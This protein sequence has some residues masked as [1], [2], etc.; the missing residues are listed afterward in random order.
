M[1]L[2]FLYLFGAL[3]LSFMCSILEAVLLSTP[4]SFISMKESQ[5]VKAA[6]RLK[7]YKSDID[8]PV[9]AILSLNTIAHTIGAAGVGSESVKIFGQEY[10][11]I[12]SAILTL[13]ILVFSEIIPKTVGASYWRSLAIPVTGIIHWLVI[14]TY[15]LVLLS[16]LITRVFS[17][18]GPQQSVSREEVSAMVS[19]GAE[20]GVFEPK[21]NKVIQSFIKLVN[22]TAKEIM[23]PNIVVESADERMTLREFGEKDYTYSRIPVYRENRDY[24]TGYILRA[25]VLE[26]LSEDQFE[27]KLADM[28]RPIL[29]FNEEEP[30][31]KIWEKM[32]EQREHISV[33]TDEYG[34]LRGIVT[35]EDV[36]ETML[37]V[38][39]VD[40]NDTDTDMQQV[41]REKWQRMKQR[42]RNRQNGQPQGAAKK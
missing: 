21:E 9:A 12:I 10:F 41:A 14:I 36:I 22:V 34:C 24:I 29:S 11:G 17:P 40:E 39:I 7:R 20:E 30:V 18:K 32:L 31:S 35:M 25:A 16:E 13:L 6:S 38:E 3:A 1:G 2:I 33:V 26:R 27:G 4:M 19:V 8:R 37:G 42:V 23:T 28:A 5:G 15:P